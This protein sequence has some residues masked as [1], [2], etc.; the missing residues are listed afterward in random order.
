MGAFTSGTNAF[1][2]V[3]HPVQMRVSP[4]AIDFSGLGTYD[5]TT[6]RALTALA[7]T[8]GANSQTLS[9][10]TMTVASGGTQYRPVALTNGGNAGSFVGFSAEL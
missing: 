9:V 4:T 1:V 8:S 6:D 10:V 5:W 3:K 2:Q 7:L